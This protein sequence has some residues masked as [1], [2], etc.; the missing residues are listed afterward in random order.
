MA[1]PR[2]C[3]NNGGPS[4]LVRLD[5]VPQLDVET[6]LSVSALTALSLWQARPGEVLTVVDPE[7]TAYRARITS[8]DPE[9]AFCVPFQ[10]MAKPVESQ[11]RIEIYQPLPDMERFELGLQTLTELGVARI[12]PLESQYSKK[13]EEPDA[14]QE[15]PPDW[16]EVINK[17]SRHC[18]RAMLPELL[19][20]HSFTE[21]LICAASTEL[22][23]M[24]Y[25]G[26][27]LWTFTEGVGS[28]RPQ[29][30]ALLIGPEGGFSCE[31][32]EK[33]QA[34]GFLPVCLGPRHLSTETAAIVAVALAQ[35]Y[36]GDLG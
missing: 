5:H 23:L 11:L 30:V 31:E 2:Q 3:V 10:R 12:V 14:R 16:P 20:V 33:A 25:E 24:F 17:A 19:A 15:E 26:D 18:R 21:A 22:K 35:S 34:E 28:F 8:L 27:A 32:I 7:T 4:S 13:L 9:R 36:L 1:L 29:S 6:S